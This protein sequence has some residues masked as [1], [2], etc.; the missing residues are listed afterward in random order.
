MPLSKERW[1][2]LGEP[3]HELERKALRH[4]FLNLPDREPWTVWTNVEFTDEE[5]RINE[6]DALVLTP[7]GLALVEVKCRPGV[8]TGDT[9]TWTWT[10]DGRRISADNPLRLASAKAKRLA[11][12]LRKHLTAPHAAPFVGELVF[13]A[14]DPPNDIKL[15]SPVRAYGETTNDVDGII[16]A[17]KAPPWLRPSPSHARPPHLRVDPAQAQRIKKALD[18][19]GI[20]PWMRQRQAGDYILDKLLEDNTLEGWQDWSGH[21]VHFTDDKVRV[22]LYPLA[23]SR[24]DAE[25]Q[26]RVKTAEREYAALRDVR[27][28][29][30]LSPRGFSPTDLGPALIFPETSGGQRLD[31]WVKDQ[32]RPPEL[33]TTLHLL[34][35]IADAL[36]HAHGSRIAH[37]ALSPQSVLVQAGRDGTLQPILIGWQKVAR[38]GTSSNG[39]A[40]V[41]GTRLEDA[42]PDGNRVWLAPEID[43]PNAAALRL[44]VYSFGTL[45]WL[46]L[47]GAPPADTAVE[48]WSRLQADSGLKLPFDG[49]PIPQPLEDLLFDCTRLEAK[50]RPAHG[51]EILQ[52]LQEV[53]TPE[54]EEMATGRRTVDPDQAEPGDPLGHDL[55]MERSLGRGATAHALLVRRDDTDKANL[56]LKVALD[57]KQNDRLVEEGKALKAL[58]HDRIVRC[59]DIVT[60]HGRTALLLDYAGDRTLAQRLAEDGCPDIALLERW[61]R[62]LLSAVQYL[63]EQGIFHRDIKPDNLGIEKT[64]KDLR[65]KLFDFSLVGASRDSLEV[66]TR[67]YLDPFLRLRPNRRWDEAAD[68]FSAAVVLH[69][70][71][72]GLVPV[73]GDGESDPALLE[74]EVSLDRDRFPEPLRNSLFEFFYR[75]LKRDPAHRHVSAEAMADAWATAF[76]PLRD[77]QAQADQEQARLLA[78]HAG[79]DIEVLGL[80]AEAEQVLRQRS[81][82]SVGAFLETPRK[83]YRYMRGVGDALRKQI[84]N[85]AKRLARLRPDLVPPDSVN[86]LPEKRGEATLEGLLETMIPVVPFDDGREEEER[87]LGLYLGIADGSSDTLW[88]DLRACATQ[89]R[90]RPDRMP[91]VVRTAV[92]AW[93]ARAKDHKHPLRWLVTA[94]DELAAALDQAGGALTLYE[95]ASI[96]ITRIGTLEADREERSS[97]ALKVLR[98]VALL[99]EHAEPPAWTV[100]AS[101]ESG[102]TTPPL[103]VRSQAVAE[104][105]HLASHCLRDALAQRAVLARGDALAL[106]AATAPMPDGLGLTPDRLLVLAVAALDEADLSRAGLVYRIGLPAEQALDYA[107]VSLIGARHGFPPEALAARVA[108]L[109]PHAEALPTDQPSLQ[110]MLQQ[111]DIPLPWDPASGQFRPPG[112]SLQTESTAASRHDPHGLTAA[113]LE[114]RIRRVCRE[115]GFLAVMARPEKVRAAAR[116]LARLD[117]RPVDAEAALIAALRAT[118]ERL[119]VV[120]SRVELADDPADPNWPRLMQLVA[121]SRFDLGTAL[122]APGDGPV[123]LTRAGLLVRYGLLGEL[124]R[125]RDRA[126]AGWP[127]TVLLVSTDTPDQ[128]CIEGRALP[129]ISRNEWASLPRDWIAEAVPVTATV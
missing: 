72:T 83:Y 112:L 75:A 50:K 82:D 2:E 22:R 113:G 49:P 48:L 91:R 26:R 4:L 65:L 98:A 110:A 25:R 33:S 121:E 34:R 117:L 109:F 5:G 104:P 38:S 127:S 67:P 46:L 42:L 18:K 20:R 126:G 28:P 118:A 15:P 122:G 124:G 64:S 61:G 63:C 40:A 36:R 62:D 78:L 23:R 111:A 77:L 95:A 66:G 99:A 108:E 53:G 45:A 123:L 31:L 14:G 93:L 68:R 37:R 105:I 76:Q 47:T 1:L 32:G 13:L 92:E 44:D 3:A 6:V 24:T 60:L 39:G 81:I 29:A 58:T 100:Q 101:P 8:V 19:I 51:G 54:P 86:L 89:A 97:V 85:E 30:I 106:L 115:G 69:E 27:H 73:W 119:G 96:L 55:I 94:R 9:H 129:V 56:V 128:P 88:P 114:R 84:R 70:M 7:T 16:G 17:L 52:R 12:L 87:A 10:A 125:L 71:A 59:H 107:G 116:R 41:T 103:L 79:Q 120:W 90:L 74:E 57:A 11:G 102:P 43:Q 21:H 35:G 80:G